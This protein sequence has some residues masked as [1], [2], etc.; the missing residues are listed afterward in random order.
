MTGR[1][2]TVP[3]RNERV[4]LKW[5]TTDVPGANVRLVMFVVDIKKSS[6]VVEVAMK[7]SFR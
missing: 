3:G 2:G 1:D 7:T 6:A 5:T 4:V